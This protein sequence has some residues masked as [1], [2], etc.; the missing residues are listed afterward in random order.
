MVRQ[1]LWGA[2]VVT[3]MRDGVEVL[4]RGRGSKREQRVTLT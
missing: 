3:S 2:W 4:A 1:L